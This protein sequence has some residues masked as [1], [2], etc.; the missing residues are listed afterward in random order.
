MRRSVVFFG[1]LGL[2]ACQDNVPTRPTGESAPAAA[3]AAAGQQGPAFVPGELVV[4][5]RDDAEAEAVAAANGLAVGSRGYA[6]AFVVMRGAVGSEQALAARLGADARVVWAEPNW[7][8]QPTRVDP[9]PRLWAFYNPG[10]LTVDFTRGPSKGSAVSSYASTADADVDA[11][12]SDVSAGFAASGAPVVIGSIDTGVQFGHPEFLSGQ[13]IAGSDWYSGDNDPSDSD[14]HGTHTTGTMAGQTVGVAGVT[15]AGGNVKVYVQ[16][17]CGPLGC[18]LSAIANAI[19]E[20]ADYPGMVAMNLSLGGSSESQGEKDAIAYA[21]AKG[22]LVIASAGNGG[23]GTVGCPACDP[24]AISVGALNWQ[25]ELSYYTNWGSGLDLTA[26]GGEL[27]S[28]TTSEAGIYSAYINSGYAYMQGTS[29]AAPIV[30]G[31]A[32]VVASVTGARGAALRARLEGN[33]DD[34]GDSG[35]D[36]HFGNG[37]VNVLAAA[38]G[39]AGEGGGGGGGGG[40]DG[41]TAPT[42]AFS[43]NCGNTDTCLFDASASTGAT[44][45]SWDFGGGGPA[46]TDVTVSNTFGAGSFIVTLTVSDADATTPDDAA[47]QQ[48]SCAVRGKTL[49]CR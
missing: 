2:A 10:G 33:A 35:Y 30:T 32:G 3:F 13:L 49:R 15:G 19:R 41:P 9:D 8:R 40:D 17:V 21:T 4:K 31:A 26:P 7:L 5:L 12:G 24:N 18:P 28:N 38:T 22:V 44:S 43:Y 27:Y 39:S 42:A 20:A 14:G 16:R 1:I 34:L 36:T 48:I 37:R 46:Q 11:A 6:R 23:T 45:Y 25:D 29:M 47:Q